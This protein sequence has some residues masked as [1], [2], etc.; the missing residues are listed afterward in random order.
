MGASRFIGRVGGL[1]VALGVGAAAFS[2]S[3][4]AWADPSESG[5]D[6]SSTPGSSRS[7]DS[8]STP[9][10]SRKSAAASPAAGPVRSANRPPRN[11]RPDQG[12]T[13]SA[14]SVT[15]DRD[16]PDIPELDS[17]AL[18]AAVVAAPAAVRQSAPVRADRQNSAG[19]AASEIIAPVAEP[20]SAP[21]PAPVG[22]VSAFLT[23][24]DN[25][26][27][28]GVG[29]DPLAPADSPL[30]WA[31]LAFAR[32]ESLGAAASAN[33]VASVTASQSVTN[34]GV[35]VD[36]T[37]EFADGIIY[38]S[39]DAT[40]SRGLE[41]KYTVIGGRSGG[42]NGGKLTLATYPD[43]FPEAD[44]FTLLPYRTWDN[45]GVGKGEETWQVRVSEVTDFDKFI[46]GIPLLGLL[47][48][49]IIDLLQRA[50]FLSD[51]LAPIIGGSVMATVTADVAALAPLLTPV[52]YT[53]KVESFD[54]TLISTNFFPATG[55][56]IGEAAPTVLSGPGLGTP[57]QTNPYAICGICGSDPNKTGETLGIGSLRGAGFNAVSWDP[58]GEFD[59]G[60][61]LQL[62]NPFFEGRDVSALVSWIATDTPAEFN[63]PGDPKVGMVG[64][65]YGGGIQ[66]TAAST[67]P[68][69]DAIVPDIAWNS[70]DE[71]L[72]PSET[73]KTA[74]PSLLLLS[75]VTTGARINPQI[76]AAIVTGDLLGW[77]SDRS[78]AVLSSSGPTSL[79]NQLK[80][81]TLLTQGTIDVLFPLNQSLTNAQTI[82][83]N[84]FDT[85]VKVIWFCG[86]HGVCAD[87]ISDDQAS[88]LRDASLAWLI[89]YVAN[90]GV[91]ADLI[92]R[93]QW[94]DQLGD[95][96][97]SPLL[98]NMPGFNDLP[99]V[100]AT[101]AGG[102]LGILPIIGGS[103]PGAG[104]IPYSLG[105][106]AP[107]SNAINIDL[108]IPA[109]S[110][111][112]GAPTV[113]FTYQGIGTSRAVFAQVIDN[114]TGRVLGNLVTPVPVTLDG[115]ERQVSIDLND[116][117]YTN[118][119]VTPGSLTLQITSSATA[120]ENFISLGL[121]NITDIAVTVPNRNA[122]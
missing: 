41:L 15:V 6:S 48:D 35:T 93:F 122:V 104:T 109:D 67:D 61:V 3:A 31:L 106:G 95:R 65:S 21:E 72:Y 40:S 84:P 111:V 102:L 80:A 39:L 14:P 77:L 62:D 32:R 42:S 110:Q 116:I 107:A 92:P 83:Q 59:S 27:A 17:D 49:P 5:S 23:E 11:S 63:D 75:L 113:S 117:V 2:G 47:A 12:P 16:I 78:Q 103:G 115:R 64:G 50:P 22:E 94:F 73:F 89:Q 81:P 9:A 1:A 46:T 114:S 87:P 121:V 13:R 98:P 19:P 60:G 18:P 101:N 34:N 24:A 100:T 51:L 30:E 20:V 69:I 33:Q 120:Y 43:F 70:L 90:D 53:Y 26:L 96:Y 112:V 71:S 28:D 54:G 10:R 8:P 45:A 97:S 25:G 86:G 85:P 76:Y 29:T 119:G 37:V 74:Y 68:R 108:S 44:Q 38:G 99:A 79:L 36:P 88:T 118:G 66:L 105:N 82:M 4:V 57:G 55:L 52:A 56:G 7:E 58:R 91:P